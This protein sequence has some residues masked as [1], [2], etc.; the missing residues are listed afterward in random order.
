MAS[1]V[2]VARGVLE[3]LVAASATKPAYVVF[4]VPNSSY[5]LHLRPVPDAAV[6]APHPG[7]RLVGTITVQA[8]RVDLVRTG[9]RLVE[10]VHGRPRRVH[11]TVIAH[12]AASRSITVNAGGAAAVDSLPLPIVLKLTD[13]RNAPE[14]FPIGS[15]VACDVLDGG[16]F[17]PA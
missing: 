17:Q 2:S 8:R 4:A 10:P 16:T 1:N 11:G 5:K 15:L 6:I 14:Q 7:K 12:D 3:E 13:A 9:G